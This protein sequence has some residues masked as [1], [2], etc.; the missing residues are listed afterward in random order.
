MMPLCSSSNTSPILASSG[1]GAR[2]APFTADQNDLLARHL[3]HELSCALLRQTGGDYIVPANSSTESEQGLDTTIELVSNNIASNSA[4]ELTTNLDL[5][6]AELAG[7]AHQIDGPLYQYWLT[8]TPRGEDSELSSLS[9][10]AYLLRPDTGIIE[11]KTDYMVPV[12]SI[13]SMPDEQRGTLIGQ[14]SFADDAVVFFIEHQ[15]HFGLVRLDSGVCRDR[16][17]AKECW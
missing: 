2:D 12:R 15:P 3:A 7:K 1:L 5:A 6:N 17:M 4:I 8:V 11:P 16:T 13:V 14:H 10:S 9:V